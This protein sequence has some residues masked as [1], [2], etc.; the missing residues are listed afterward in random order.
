VDVWKIVHQVR[1]AGCVK[2][3]ILR[4][5]AGREKDAGR[6]YESGYKQQCS[7]AKFFGQAKY[8]KFKRET[9]FRSGHC[10]SKHRMKRYAS[11]LRGHGSLAPPSTS[12]VERKKKEQ[13]LL[14]VQSSTDKKLAK[15]KD[16]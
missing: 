4:N 3:V 1:S 13:Y 11:N 2:G 6:L 15:T 10:L 12:V 9:V 8:F 14:D 5:M 7:Q 16:R